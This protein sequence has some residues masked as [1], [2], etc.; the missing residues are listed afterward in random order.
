MSVDKRGK[1]AIV[2]LRLAAE[3]Q[4]VTREAINIALMMYDL[5]LGRYAVEKKV[6]MTAWYVKEIR[7][8]YLQLSQKDVIKYTKK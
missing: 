7:D 1:G 8:V 6:E 4:P 5:Y 2:Q 3:A